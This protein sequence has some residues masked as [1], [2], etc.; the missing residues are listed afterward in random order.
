[1][2]ASRSVS[3]ALE[4]LAKASLVG[5]KTVKGP[6]P[7]S[8]SARPAADTAANRVENLPETKFIRN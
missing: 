8:V 7:D 1:M 2:L 4:I 5:A 3:V 6:L